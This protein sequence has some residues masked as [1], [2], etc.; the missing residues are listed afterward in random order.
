MPPVSPEFCARAGNR[1]SIVQHIST[2]L[3]RRR[4]RSALDILPSATSVKPAAETHPV[5]ALSH[6]ATASSRRT[7]VLLAAATA[8]VC[9]VGSL[10]LHSQ[11][12]LAADVKVAVHYSFYGSGRAILYRLPML[13]WHR[14]T[15]KRI[16]QQAHTS[17]A[18][19]RGLLAFNDRTA[20]HLHPVAAELVNM[21]TMRWGP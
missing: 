20:H 14:P 7:I 12:I 5:H 3:T 17:R 9:C 16:Q 1:C 18:S 13:H 4:T 21:Q 6:A 8:M 11:R 15:R 2:K 10:L 19:P